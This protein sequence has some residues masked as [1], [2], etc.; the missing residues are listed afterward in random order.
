[1]KEDGNYQKRKKIVREQ[2]EN[3]RGMREIR[4]RRRKKNTDGNYLKRRKN[5]DKDESAKEGDEGDLRGVYLR[6]G[7]KRLQTMKKKEARRWKLSEKKEKN[8][9]KNENKREIKEIWEEKEEEE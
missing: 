6:E 5:E 8:E 1:M 9:D 2:A 3:E 4:K 7:R